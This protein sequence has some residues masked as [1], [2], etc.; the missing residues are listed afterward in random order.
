MVFFSMLILGCGSKDETAAKEIVNNFINYL[1]NGNKKNAAEIYEKFSLYKEFHLPKDFKIKNVVERNEDLTVIGEYKKEDDQLG[2]MK[3]YF[4]KTNEGHLKLV[5]T[6][7]LL[8]TYD[9]DREI[10]IAVSMGCL[11]SETETDLQLLRARTI[12]ENYLLKKGDFSDLN[13][14]I[15]ITDWE[16]NQSNS[17]SKVY[18]KGAVLSELPF[19]MNNLELEVKFY[20]KDEK[21]ITSKK[22]VI[23]TLGRDEGDGF[24]FSVDYIGSSK[25]ATIGFNFS[26]KNL[27]Q[28]LNETGK[29]P[30]I[31]CQDFLN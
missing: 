16:W 13:N 19:D 28:Y 21:L 18:V 17:N 31:N 12:V 23:Y 26:E 10:K 4:Q 2:E 20:G 29:V 27:I 9:F 1:N 8:L 22:D 30:E 25:T 5:D 14:K 24:T 11:K 6:K 15:K 3:F 7:F